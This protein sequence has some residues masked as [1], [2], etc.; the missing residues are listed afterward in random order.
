MMKL[1]KIVLAMSALTFSGGVLAHGYI[2]E[3]ASRDEMCRNASTPNASCGQAQYE[4]QST[5]EGPDG[6]P[7]AGPKDG[8][9]ASGSGATNW[10]GEALNQQSSDRWVKHKVTPGPLDI[11]WRFTAAHPIADYRYYIT[12]QDWNPNHPLTRDAFE[13]TPFCVIPGG[14]AETSGTATHTCNLPE[15][16]GY[17]VIYGAWDVSDTAATFYKVIDVEF[18]DVASVWKRTVGTIQPSRNLGQGDSVKSRLFDA[19]G[20]RPDLSVSVTI[21]TEQAGQA[22]AW[23]LALAQK[24]N[25][26]YDHVRAGVKN[27]EGE[28][29][30][31]AGANTLYALED[32]PIVRIEI[33]VNAQSDN[34]P[35]I[36]LTDTPAQ[37]TLTEGKN[38]LPIKVKAVGKMIINARLYNDKQENVGFGTALLE[39]DEQ[40]VVVDL[41][42]ALPG[43]HTFVVEGRAPTG[44]NYQQS[45]DT[46]LVQEG[47]GQAEYTYPENIKKYVAGTRVMQPKTKQ[48]FECK[49]FPYSGW[50]TI[51]SANANQFEPGVGS[52][53]QDAWILVNGAQQK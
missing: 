48:I 5:G 24:I 17:Q 21:D 29:V 39:D 34:R 23:S 7:A 4:P 50:C 3:P 6:F 13:L 1:K 26:T 33:E 45:F 12:K 37:Y 42:K 25:A 11:T 2:S 43:K 36:T 16:R 49:P 41:W 28:V 14:P 53:W 27:S 47:A 10:I 44:I 35:G 52:N 38:S 18:D 51:Y 30:P 20:E 9:L 46:T 40:T 8:E 15:R 19:K 22:N 32:S 31:A